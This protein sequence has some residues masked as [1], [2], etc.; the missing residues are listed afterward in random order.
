M[1]LKD[2]VALVTGAGQGV[3]EGIARALHAR[4]AQVVIA[5]YDTESGNRVAQALDNA[6]FQQ[7]D[8]RDR[9]QVEDAVKQTISTFG[10][11]D[12]LVNNAYPTG[13]PPARLETRED[14]DFERALTGGFM[15]PWWA[16]KAAF[17]SM[18][19]RQWGRVINVCSLNGVNAHP[20]TVEY[21]SA[22]EALRAL[23]RTAAREWA[24]H[25]ICVN[26]ICPAARTPAYDRFERYTPENAALMLKQNPMG[27]MGDPEADIGG[28]VAFL[29]SDD[30]RYVTGNTLFADGGSHIN[31]VNWEPPVA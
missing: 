13:T 19:G 23:S 16:M 15:A 9:A 21:N 26:V 25:G 10:H 28:V 12:I 20:Y 22:K 2:K 4:G 24:K 6:V 5:E 11:L 31:G 18:Q 30:A 29:A 14:E 17:E 3:G 27:R 7:V 8:I 1:V